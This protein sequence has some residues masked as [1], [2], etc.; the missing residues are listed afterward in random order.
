M[1]S[2]SH[3][4]ILVGGEAGGGNWYGKQ[5]P[6]M[7][8][9]ALETKLVSSIPMLLDDRGNGR[10][11]VT[12]IAQSIYPTHLCQLRHVSVHTLTSI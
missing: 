9:M 4:Q 11:N 10:C 8:L 6:P 3:G 12:T 7:K 2:S 5:L 1:V